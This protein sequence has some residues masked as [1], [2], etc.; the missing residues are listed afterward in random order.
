MALTPLTERQ[1]TLIV[2]NVVKAIKDITK[3]NKTGY[4]F[5]YLASGF[6]AHYNIEGFKAHYFHHSLKRDILDNER[7]NQW[8]NFRAGD[9]DFDYYKSKADVYNRIVTAIK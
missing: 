1:K 4:N 8:L 7:S 3:L 5:L 6:I 2:N 9:K